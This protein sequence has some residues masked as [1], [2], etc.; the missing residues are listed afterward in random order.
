MLFVFIFLWLQNSNEFIRRA[1]TDICNE[2]QWMKTVTNILQNWNCFAFRLKLYRNSFGFG[3]WWTRIVCNYFNCFDVLIKIVCDF[4]FLVDSLKS[5]VFNQQSFTWRVTS[6]LS[7]P[8]E[9]W[10]FTFFYE[11]SFHFFYY[12]YCAKKIIPKKLS[13]WVEEHP[14]DS[15]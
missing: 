4:P 1:H 8:C 14:L 5:F 2:T 6:L 7:S 9:I 3:S 12:K 15:S 13:H 11:I 10:L